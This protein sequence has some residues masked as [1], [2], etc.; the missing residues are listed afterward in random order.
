MSLDFPNFINSG[1]GI[2]DEW[3]GIVSPCVARRMQKITKDQKRT[4]Y[5][6]DGAYRIGVIELVCTMMLLAKA[7]KKTHEEEREFE[8]VDR[9]RAAVASG[10][11]VFVVERGR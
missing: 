10:L 11:T 4:R 2:R 3:T 9:A 5:I 6:E 8:W 1:T 7:A